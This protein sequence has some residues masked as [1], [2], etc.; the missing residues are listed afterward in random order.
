MGVL[1]LREIAGALGCRQ[2]ELPI[3]YLGLKV[4]GR[5]NGADCWVDT[6]EKVKSRVKRW[7]AT[8]LSMGGENYH[9]QIYSLVYP[10]L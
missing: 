6:V 5:V 9:C 3:P 7:D 2:G 1:E 10:N 4:G 8:T